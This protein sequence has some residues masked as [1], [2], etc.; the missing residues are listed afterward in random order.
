VKR[1]VESGEWRVWRVESGECRE[2]SGE[3]SGGIPGIKT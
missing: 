1:R 3:E 2:E